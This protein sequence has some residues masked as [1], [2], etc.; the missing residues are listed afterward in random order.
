VAKV[1]TRMVGMQQEGFLALFVRHKNPIQ[2]NTYPMGS[3]TY[4]STD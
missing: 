3:R 1:K 2:T 4:I